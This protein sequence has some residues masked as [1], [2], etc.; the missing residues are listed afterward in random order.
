MKRNKN[1]E[2]SQ[3]ETHADGYQRSNLSSRYLETVRSGLD[4]AFTAKELMNNNVTYVN[5]DADMMDRRDQHR[6]SR[7]QQLMKDGGIGQDL[8]AVIESDDS[9]FAVVKVSQYKGGN[10][11]PT[12]RHA[13][14]WVDPGLGH[15]HTIGIVGSE[16][17][18]NPDGHV[19]VGRSHPYG[20]Q[21]RGTMSRT[22]FTVG[23][24]QMDHSGSTI[25]IQDGSETLGSANGNLVTTGYD[26]ARDHSNVD[27]R[28]IWWSI[29]E[30][31]L[32][33]ELEHADVLADA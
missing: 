15:A 4:T 5:T 23:Y 32:Q 22:Q 28:Q 1:A 10:R 9:L 21:F 13:V 11:L 19:R 17:A 20:A 2:P 27:T 12:V 7:D 25:V 18:R 16:N 6:I 3:N 31:Q 33:V 29:D 26:L 8:V 14:A 24:D 30:Q